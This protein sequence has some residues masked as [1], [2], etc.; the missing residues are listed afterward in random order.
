M[1]DSLLGYG[2]LGII[3]FLALTGCGLPVP[4]EVPVIA[5][6]VLAANGKMDPGLALGSC[7][8]GAL[9]GDCIMYYI[10]FHFGRSVLRE[11][12]LWTHFLTP[13]RERQI[14]RMIQRHGIKVF[15][16]SRF[17]VGLRS[18]MYITAGILHVPFR[19]FFLVD[20]FNASIVTCTFFGLSYYFGEHIGAW[21]KRAE[22]AVTIIVVIA[23]IATAV[24]FYILHRR[25]K[26]LRALAELEESK[27]DRS[28]EPSNN[29]N[30]V[31]E[32]GPG[33]GGAEEQAS[34]RAEEG[35]ISN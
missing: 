34:R 12:P 23:V 26:A 22:Y 35:G 29:G 18:P 14:E 5:A 7:L 13:E 6:G 9:L 20:I 8:I 24:T 11:H 10:G 3:A 16:A 27:Q 32:P 30:A 19:K 15:F 31:E 17:L 25:Q 2:Y 33:S 4:E 21:I 1:L 28:A